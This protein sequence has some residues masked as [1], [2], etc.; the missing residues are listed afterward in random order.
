VH[1]RYFIKSSLLSIAGL[2]FTPAFALTTVAQ[3][4]GSGKKRKVL[5]LLFQ[6]GAA[7]GLSLVPPLAEPRYAA[8]RPT[9]AIPATGEGAALPLDGFFGLHPALGPLLPLWEEGQLA[10]LH[11]AGSPD[12]SRSHFDAQDYMELGTPGQKPEDGFL[13]RALRQQPEDG[14]PPFRAVALQPNLPLSLTGPAPVVAMSSLNDFGLDLAPGSAAGGFEGMYRAA[15]DHTLRGVGSEAFEALH[16][17]RDAVPTGPE[18]LLAAGYPRSPLGRRLYEIAAL[19]KADLGLEIAATDAG[20]WDTHAGQGGSRGQLA[21]RLADLAQA[22]AAFSRDLGPRW[23]DVVLVMCTEFGRTVRQ[24]GTQG[25]DHGHG[26]V[27]FVLGGR[28]RGRRV[29]ARWNGLEEKDLF[30]GRD[31]A[32][33]TDFRAPLSRILKEHLGVRDV[34][35]VFPGFAVDPREWP[36]VV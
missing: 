29:Y 12:P 4:V 17:I 8:V 13:N 7:D 24:N 3:T 32:V 31:L 34:A 20:G 30:E 2:S 28:V 25:T 11:A 9:L 14:A 26:A 1:R 35:S 36:R 18:A 5:V 19:I 22:L 27:M 15:V 10:L 21:N 6:R 33:T 16:A 23:D